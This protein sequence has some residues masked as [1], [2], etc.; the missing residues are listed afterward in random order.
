M[1]RELVSS[2]K[3]AH[4]ALVGWPIQAL[5]WLEWGLSFVGS[6]EQSMDRSFSTA[7]G[8]LCTGTFPYPRMNP[9]RTLLVM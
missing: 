3:A 9:L 2:P 7:E 1:N 5:F 8:I 4:A 6:G